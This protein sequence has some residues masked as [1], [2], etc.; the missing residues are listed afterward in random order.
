MS[1][2][3][4]NELDI[5]HVPMELDIQQTVIPGGEPE[6]VDFD[7]A[8]GNYYELID[9]GKAAINTAMHVAA[10]TQNP[11]ALEVLSGLL[12]NMADI[13]KQLVMMS[14]DRADVKSAKKQVKSADIPQV[15]HQTNNIIMSGSLRDITRLLKE[16][17]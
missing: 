11:R 13:N 1:E 7:A 15:G 9:Q 16:Q 6:D 14:K 12:K 5:E 3:L 8:R 2:K 17:V 4:A 10:E